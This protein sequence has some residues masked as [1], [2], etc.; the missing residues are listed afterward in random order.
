VRRAAANDGAQ[1]DQGIEAFRRGQPLPRHF[2]PR[3]P[4]D[5]QIM[6]IGAMAFNVSSARQQAVDDKTVEPT[7]TRQSAHPVS[8]VH[9]PRYDLVHGLPGPEVIS[10][11]A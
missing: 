11:V 2:S 5:L 6:R 4:D 7:P 9:L 8:P 3:H 1:R 10:L